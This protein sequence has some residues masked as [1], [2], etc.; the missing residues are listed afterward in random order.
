MS[1]RPAARWPAARSPAA[2]PGTPNAHA[3]ASSAMAALAATTAVLGPARASP[4]AV[5]SGPARHGWAGSVP[6]SAGVGS[7]S[8]GTARHDYLAGL[9]RAGLERARAG[10]GRAA[11]LD[12]YI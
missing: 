6:C 12:I 8:G 11:R 10:P 3:K 7:P 4:W 2:R 1:S 5:L 9:K